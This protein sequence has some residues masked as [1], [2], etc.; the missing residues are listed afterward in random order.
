VKFA[1]IYPIVDE[2]IIFKNIMNMNIFLNPI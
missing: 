1:F 2:V